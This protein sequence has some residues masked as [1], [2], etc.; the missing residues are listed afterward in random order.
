MTYTPG[1]RGAARKNASPSRCTS[2]LGGAKRCSCRAGMTRTYHR[3]APRVHALAGGALFRGARFGEE[4][5]GDLLGQ[6]RRDLFVRVSENDHGQSV[7]REALDGG[8]E[9]GR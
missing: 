1:S 7:V 6:G 2:G 4:E 5:R 8:R 9:A 3:V